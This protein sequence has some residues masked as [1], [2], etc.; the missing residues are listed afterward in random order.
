MK[1]IYDKLSCALKVLYP[2]EVPMHLQITSRTTTLAKDCTTDQF[3]QPRSVQNSAAETPLFRKFSHDL[4][5]LST[6]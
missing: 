1:S 3:K 4:S 6:A 2:E 5:K